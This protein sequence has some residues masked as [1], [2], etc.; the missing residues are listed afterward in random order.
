[1]ELSPRKVS[2]ILV[3]T[4]VSLTSDVIKLAMTWN[5]DLVFLDEFGT[6]Y[7]RVWHCRLGSTTRIRRRQL[8]EGLFGIAGRHHPEE[9]G[10]KP[11]PDV[12]SRS[13]EKVPASATVTLF[14]LTYTD[15]NNKRPLFCFKGDNNT[16]AAHDMGDRVTLACDYSGDGSGNTQ[17]E[18]FQLLSGRS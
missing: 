17:A 12:T 16:G 11:I 1:M 15:I 10:L 18:R 8:N 9:Q 5:I 7:G 13:R 2:S 14:H 4:G 6:P 3:T